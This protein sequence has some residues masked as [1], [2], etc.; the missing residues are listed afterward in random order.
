M[1]DPPGGKVQPWLTG[2]ACVR[3]GGSLLVI[4]QKCVLTNNASSSRRCQLLFTI[5]ITRLSSNNF[6]IRAESLMFCYYSRGRTSG[7]TW[8][9]GSSGRVFGV[10]ASGWNL[11]CFL[12][13]RGEALI[14]LLWS[15]IDLVCQ[16]EVF[17]R[18][19]SYRALSD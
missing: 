2:E 8:G 3:G 19:V 13:E 1:Q 10:I 12:A 4:K 7:W 11:F 9:R 14:V 18:L 6:S 17:L 16:N 5:T 15:R